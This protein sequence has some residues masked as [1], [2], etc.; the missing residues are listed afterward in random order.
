[1][2]SILTILYKFLPMTLVFLDVEVIS[3]FVLHIIWSSLPGYFEG[4]I[5]GMVPIRRKGEAT[6]IMGVWVI[7]IVE[8]MPVGEM[9]SMQALCGSRC[10]WSS[11]FIAFTSAN[12]TTP[13]KSISQ[14]LKPIIMV[15]SQAFLHM[16]K[17]KKCEPPD[18]HIASWGQTRQPSVFCFSAFTI[19]RCPF[20]SF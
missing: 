4:F 5:P 12:L 19:N 20:Q 15:L 18:L 6:W 17:G 16:Q 1:M 9:T 14:P 13:L 8:T 3:N 10:I 11:L 7:Y 2:I